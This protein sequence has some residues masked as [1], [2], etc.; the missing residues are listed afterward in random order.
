VSQRCVGA[1]ADL[2]DEVFFFG[3][4]C[5][6]LVSNQS[7]LALSLGKKFTPVPA[8]SA[9][10]IVASVQSGIRES[11]HAMRKSDHNEMRRSERAQQRA[12]VPTKVFRNKAKKFPLLWC[13]VVAPH[14]RMP[15]AVE[16]WFKHLAKSM[17]KTLTRA[18]KHRKFSNA[19]AQQH[20]ADLSAACDML[21]GELKRKNL[22][23]VPADKSDKFV[24]C[25]TQVLQETLRLK[26]D[27]EGFELSSDHELSSNV[28]RCCARLDVHVKNLSE[29]LTKLHGTLSRLQSSKVVGQFD[30]WLNRDEEYKLRRKS[31]ALSRIRTVRGE[32]NTLLNTMSF[33]R[34]CLN[35][36]HM[37]NQNGARPF[38]DPGA[39][40]K[41]TVSIK[42]KAFTGETMAKGGSH[43]P[44]ESV[45][46]IIPFNKQS[47]VWCMTSVVKKAVDELLDHHGPPA[48]EETTGKFEFLR[49]IEVGSS[50]SSFNERASGLTPS[51]VCLASFDHVN[52]FSTVDVEMVQS[53]LRMSFSTL[54]QRKLTP[55]TAHLTNSAYQYLVY[56]C[57]N[58][59]MN[60]CNFILCPYNGEVM[61]QR[62]GCVPTGW[63][64][65]SSLVTLV[66]R[67][68][69]NQLV[70]EFQ[71]SNKLLMM[72][73]CADDAFA[74]FNSRESAG[75][76]FRKINASSPFGVTSSVGDGVR[77]IGVN[78]FKGKRF[79]EGGSLDCRAAHAAKGYL[80]VL[81][82]LDQWKM[83]AYATLLRADCVLVR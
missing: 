76:F 34:D 61:Q 65:S 3:E 48:A 69:E 67:H 68:Y 45:R 51:S 23:A 5:E 37:K 38:N 7:F 31:D 63:P 56:D 64:S 60:D 47:L 2:C 79:R 75:Q 42:L 74:V 18:M 81:F 19:R 49:L 21:C 55:S 78:V 83:S 25:E 62:S 27:S 17:V 54:D 15:D 41:P 70:R 10:S 35:N 16:M 9:R 57:L 43:F 4:R 26:L 66:L 72:V 53:A 20:A 52:M 73:R 40:P 58:M 71:S 14:S 59:M 39:L 77:F 80:F 8:Q 36:K 22:C 30:N 6:N 28:L 50:F 29:K 32:M 82:V 13:P 44:V 12:L 33:V 24:V 1:V 46:L 11:L